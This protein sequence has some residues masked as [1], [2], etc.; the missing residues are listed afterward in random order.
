MVDEI[1][2]EIEGANERFPIREL[3]ART[4]VNSVTLRAWERRYGLLKPQRTA[5]GHR[6][7]SEEDVATIEKILALVA[8]GVPLGKVKPLLFSEVQTMPLKSDPE[9]WQE[10]VSALLAAARSY[11]SAKVE[12]LI[13]DA[14]AS[15]PINVCRDLLVEPLFAEL[16]TASDSGAALGFA[17]SELIRYASIRLSAKLSRTKRSLVITLIAGGEAPMWRLALMAL[18]LGDLE[19]SVCM[20]MRPL[21]LEAGIELAEGSEGSYTVFYQDGVWKAKD[22]QLAAQALAENPALYMCGTAPVLI[23]QEVKNRVYADLRGCF[24]ALKQLQ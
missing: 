13:R 7:Y 11:S 5:K 15:Y 4:Q 20:V 22:Q 1:E 3:S 14:F 6:L 16:A 10:S 23:Q 17:E 18:E 9:G 21:T 19:F 2:K 8:R 24:E 12:H